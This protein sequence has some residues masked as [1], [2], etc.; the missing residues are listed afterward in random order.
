M[1]ENSPVPIPMHSGRLRS[2]GNRSIAVDHPGE[3]KSDAEE[4]DDSLIPGCS[5]GPLEI[6]VLQGTKR[7]HGCP[8][9]QEGST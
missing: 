8:L 5:N 7:K 6:Q 4:K 2:T 1:Q 9:C 3:G